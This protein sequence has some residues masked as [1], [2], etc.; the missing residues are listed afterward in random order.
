MRRCCAQKD[1][2]PDGDRVAMTDRTNRYMVAIKENVK[3][4]N[5]RNMST[6][7]IYISRMTLYWKFQ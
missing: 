3:T 6:G 2:V 7:C 1:I 4:C 5:D